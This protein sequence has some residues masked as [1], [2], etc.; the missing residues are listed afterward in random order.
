MIY[1]KISNQ[2]LIETKGCV[3]SYGSSGKVRPRRLAEEAHRPPHGKRSTLKW[4]STLHYIK[5]QQCL[6]KD[7]KK[8][9]VFHV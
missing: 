3:D 8:E 7:S 9:K 4:K 2:K 1:L 5:Y 6:K